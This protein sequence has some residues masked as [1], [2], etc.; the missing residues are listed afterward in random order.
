MRRMESERAWAGRP[1]A[2][3]RVSAAR[4]STAKASASQRVSEVRLRKSRVDSPDENRAAPLVG[5]T[6]LGPAT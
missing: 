5:K 1:S 6:W 3:A 4:A 2:T